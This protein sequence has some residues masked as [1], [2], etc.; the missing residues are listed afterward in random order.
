MSRSSD[1][2]VQRLLV[3]ETRSDECLVDLAAG[4][5]DLC[6]LL[7]RPQVSSAGFLLRIVKGRHLLTGL[8]T[9]AF[10][11]QPDVRN[12]SLS[13]HESLTCQQRGKNL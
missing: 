10:L 8:H 12:V 3:V 5:A 2:L 9:E 4:E 13:H 7:E 1:K 11:H 6:Q